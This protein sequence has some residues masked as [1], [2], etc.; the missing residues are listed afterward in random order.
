MEGFLI[1]PDNFILTRWIFL[2][3]LG[4][5]YLVAFASFSVQVTGLIGKNGILPAGDFLASVY[6][7][8][9]RRGVL[10]YPTLVW[11]NA[12]DAFMKGL[13][14]AGIFLALLLLLGIETTPVLAFLFIFYLSLVNAGQVFLSYQWDAL[15]VE[16]GFLSIFLVS[17]GLLPYQEA[18]PPSP[19][20]ILLFRWLLFR[21][22]FMSGIVK[23]TSGDPTWKHLTALAFH[24]ET[25]PLPTPLAWVMH[26]ASLGFQKFSTLFTLFVELVVP[27]F[28]FAPDLHRFVAG[29]LIIYLMLLIMATGNYAFFNILA[30]GLAIFLFDD[31][32]LRP[33]L[34]DS[35]PG[36]IPP[37]P[38][39][40]ADPAWGNWVLLPLFAIYLV[41]GIVYILTRAT[42]RKGFLRYLQPLLNI[43]GSLRIA[44]A[45]GL[46][47]VMTTQ[48]PE[49]ILEGSNDGQNWLPYEFKYKPGDLQRAPPVVAPHQPRLDWQMWFAA[50]GSYASNPWF[51]RFIE[52]VLTGSPEVLRLI[53]KNPFP[54]KPPRYI[55][56][57]L[58]DYHFTTP[59][60]KS[61]DGSWWRRQPL[62]LY[63]PPATL[64]EEG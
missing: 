49:I 25:Q 1:D 43:V 16:T 4:L 55:R 39:V 56:A 51:L 29:G 36:L 21:L 37:A 61:Q 10:F 11:L 18:A 2:R 26:R 3:V 8:M 52:R 28:F 50:L 53:A 60:E 14:F 33:I 19:I 23:L 40:G 41:T 22:M 30:I 38:Q 62:D 17:P 5:V 13:C 12:S 9:G 24:Y 64:E 34:P 7:T 46:F 15:L 59:E 45:Y 27:W 6:K 32:V 31:R 47:A 42:R 20:A 48:R 57:V 54:D 58:Y 63:L 44:N 35:F